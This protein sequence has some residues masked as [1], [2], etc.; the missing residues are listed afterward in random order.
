MTLE[1][2]IKILTVQITGGPTPHPQ[3]YIDA[4]QLGIE[5]LKITLRQRDI[6]TYTC[7]T[8]LPGETKE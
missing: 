3:D 1:E 4:M 6:D 7:N 5:A 8:T 2:A